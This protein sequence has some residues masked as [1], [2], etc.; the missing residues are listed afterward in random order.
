MIQSPRGRA[1]AAKTPVVVPKTLL[2][3]LARSVSDLDQPSQRGRRFWCRRHSHRGGDVTVLH[4]PSG[5]FA[6]FCQR[7][8]QEETPLHGLCLCAAD[9]PDP[10]PPA[11]FKV[12]LVAYFVELLEVWIHSC[13]EWPFPE[14]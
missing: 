4:H 13:F 9:A 6:D 3:V 1:V 2:D 10:V 11:L 7:K 12:E 8:V 5:Q 14:H